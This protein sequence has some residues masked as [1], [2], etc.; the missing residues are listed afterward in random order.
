MSAD[1]YRLPVLL[2]DPEEDEKPPAPQYCPDCRWYELPTY[3]RGRTHHY[4]R[5]RAPSEHIHPATG[6][7]GFLFNHDF[8]DHIRE[9]GDYQC[10]GFVEKNPPKA[11]AIKLHDRTKKK[12][13]P[14]WKPFLFWRWLFWAF[15]VSEEK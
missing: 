9:R 3:A 8:C 5:C 15:F 4:A 6:K 13:K 11:S 1:P 14:P 2:A 12:T 7:P 10:K